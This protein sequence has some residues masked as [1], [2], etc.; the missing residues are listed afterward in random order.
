MKLNELNFIC[1]ERYI[2]ITRK[3]IIRFLMEEKDFL[4]DEEKKAFHDFALALDSAIVNKYHSILQELKVFP[5][6][7][8]C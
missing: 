7:F 1:R 4:T 8:C 5:K 3:S 6:V 2:P